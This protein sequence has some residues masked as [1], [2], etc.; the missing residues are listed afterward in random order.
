MNL[1]HFSKTQ[2]LK[3]IIIYFLLFLAGELLGGLIFD[4]VFYFV[5]LPIRAL[6]IILRLSGCLLLT[7]LLF[8]VYTV[9]V[10]HMSMRDFGITFSIQKWGVMLA[11]LL[12]A[13]VVFVYLLIGGAAANELSPAEIIWAV[14]ASLIM[15]A[16]AGILEEMLFRGY[17]MKLLEIG[18]NRYVAVLVPS[19]VFSL[20]H[21][22]SMSGFSVPGVLLLIVSGTLVG[23]MFSVVAYKGNSI[24]SS[25]LLHAM[26]NFVMITDILHI[27]TAQD[28]Y[29][30]PLFSIIIPSDNIFLTGGEFGMEASV[31]SII[32]YL[33]VCCYVC[34]SAR[35]HEIP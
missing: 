25:V 11:V 22:P 6:Y 4:L 9:K 27:T 26:W 13:Y 28:A 15:A 7:F 32:G 14:L 16:K 19:F 20:L 29:G 10:L 21:L 2:V 18:W 5:E 33:L 12:P 35:R 24:S 34:F 30:E 1:S 31:V 17:I 23:V 8:R 3:H